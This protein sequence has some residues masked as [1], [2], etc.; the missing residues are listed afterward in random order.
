MRACL[1]G[2]LLPLYW[3]E[4]VTCTLISLPALPCLPC[5]ALCRGALCGGDLCGHR[6]PLLHDAGTGAELLRLCG[7]L[8]RQLIPC[9][10]VLR[11]V[12][13]VE[14]VASTGPAPA[15]PTWLRPQP[16]AAL[17]PEFTF[18]H[19]RLHC[20][21]CASL[22]LPCLLPLP[23]LPSVLQTTVVHNADVIPTICPGSADTLREEVMRRWAGYGQ[24]GRW[25][26]HAQVGS[27]AGGQ[28]GIW[29]GYGQV[30]RGMVGSA[31]GWL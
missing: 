17:P 3:L 13:G 15:L 26:G 28:V 2:L 16:P 8:G 18:T 27:W 12:W 19:P 31:G 1:P 22:I 24:V 9:N 20:P 23:V 6:L 7:E 14:E 21:A 29:A 25:S 10:K 30:G 11:V 5:P 4:H